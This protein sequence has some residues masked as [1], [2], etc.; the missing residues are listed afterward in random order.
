MSEDKKEKKSKGNYVF[1]NILAS[2]MKGVSDRTQMESS[3]MSMVFILCGIMTMSVYVAFFSDMILF[4]KIMAVV[5]SL[6]AFV[7]LSSNL[8][9]SFQQYQQHLIMMGIIQDEDDES[10]GGI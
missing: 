6:A 10:I 1:P 5:N 8:V 9:T 7:F 3:M 4:V 2:V